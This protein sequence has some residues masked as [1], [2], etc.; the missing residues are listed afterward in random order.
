MRILIGLLAATLAFGSA[1]AKEKPKREL[2]PLELKKS[3]HVLKWINDYR[4]APEP[5]RLPGSQRDHPVRCAV[6]RDSRP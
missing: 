1:F 4:L 5:D 2:P 3:E 6:R